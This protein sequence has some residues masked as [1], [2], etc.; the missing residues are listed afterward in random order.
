LATLERANATES[1]DAQAS[2]TRAAALADSLAPSHPALAAAAA[3]A[4]D[5]LSR[6]TVLKAQRDA[7]VRD[8]MDVTGPRIT[9]L[10]EQISTA[11]A[12]LSLKITETAAGQYRFAVIKLAGV[13]AFAAAVCLLAGASLVRTISRSSRSV[14][15]V[16]RAVSQ[17]DLTVKPINS[18]GSDELG[19][20][21]RATDAM[22]ASLRDLIGEVSTATTEVSGA[23]TQIAAS[24]E[25]MSASI[26]EVAR[27]AAQASQSAEQSGTIARS[28]GEVVVRTVEG[29][30]EIDS[31]VSA[32]AHSVEEL[33]R[34]SGEIG[35][36]VSVIKEI[37]DQTN[38]L[39]LNAAIEA[40]RAGEHGR[41]FAVVADEVR[42]LA[43]RTTKA[44]DEVASSI[45]SIQQETTQAVD[46]MGKGTEQVKAGVALAQQAGDNLRQIVDN[47][48]QVAGMIVSITSAAQEAGAGA[49]QSA[50][51]AAELSNKSEQ[52]MTMLGRFRLDSSPTR[53]H[54]PQTR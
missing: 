3:D 26:G 14:L 21:S 9:A 17:G 44:T 6:I 37:A 45:Q 53:E 23:A 31:A 20:L 15:T 7:A 49:G 39:A 27:Q 25:Q 22:A 18:A 50:A 33:G 19:E 48:A 32:S 8:G 30:S 1:P 41:G 11:L 35:R 16:L 2:I 51:A 40:A 29:M 43:E 12:P 52:L 10:A 42:K 28:G 13:A 38:L 46:R 54:R 5:A 4:A 24:S 47:T 36:V 34:R